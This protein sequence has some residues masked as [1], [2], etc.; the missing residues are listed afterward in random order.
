MVRNFI[1][2]F[3][4]GLCKRGNASGKGGENMLIATIMVRLW[5][6]VYWCWLPNVTVDHWVKLSLPLHNIPFTCPLPPPAPQLPIPLPTIPHPSPHP[7]AYYPSSPPPPTSSSPFYPLHLPLN[8]LTL[9][10][11]PS[12]LPIHSVSPPPLHPSISLST[13]T[14][15]PPP[16]PM[17]PSPLKEWKR[18]CQV[19]I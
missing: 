3:S 13:F 10:T 8:L 14:I 15:H 18:N 5:I 16:L 2:Y 19:F 17:S 11:S 9:N 12:P 6:S 1:P 7:L 4:N